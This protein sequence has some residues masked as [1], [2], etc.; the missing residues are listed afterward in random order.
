MD[1][2]VLAVL[3]G[4]TEETQFLAAGS[5]PLELPGLEVDTVGEIALPVTAATVK[6]LVKIADQAPYGRGEQTI[7][8]TDVRRVW[9]IEPDKI[10]FRN[11]N[12]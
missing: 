10:R 5:C 3:D 7:V 12:W 8:D 11:A 6:T 9:Q 4:L 2:K 1:E